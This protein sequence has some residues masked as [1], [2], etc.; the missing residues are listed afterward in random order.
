MKRFYV[1]KS[2]LNN[3]QVVLDGSEHNH[4]KNVL[5]LNEGEEVIV[6]C[7]DEFDYICKISKIAK[8]NTLL[9][10]V[11]KSENTYNP[12]ADV[13]VFQALTKSEN[14]SLIVQKLNEL[15]V[16]TFVPFESRYITSKDKFNKQDKLQ[17]VANQSVKQCKRSVPMQVEK[18]LSFAKLVESLSCFDVVIFANE[19]EKTKNLKDVKISHENKVAIIVGSEGGF[20]ED[21][22]KEIEKQPNAT[23]VSLGKR[24]LRAETASIALTGVVMYLMDEWNIWNL[25]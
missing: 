21:E 18:T 3:N 13:T 15:G 8:N 22:I 19:T 20:S 12:K 14:M 23:S 11:S 9:E 16:K 5:R 17:T 6:V 1:D 10:V 4:L 7:G 25:K 24:I 2:Q